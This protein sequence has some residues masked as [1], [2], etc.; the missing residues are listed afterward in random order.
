MHW[1]TPALGPPRP[2][3]AQLRTAGSS[4]PC[5]IRSVAILPCFS[6]ASAAEG[7]GGGVSTHATVRELVPSEGG[8]L[9]RHVFLPFSGRPRAAIPT[10]HGVHAHARTGAWM[11]TVRS[12]RVCECVVTHARAW[13]CARGGWC[14]DAYCEGPPIATGRGGVPPGR[15]RRPPAQMSPRCARCATWPGS[16]QC[17]DC[18]PPMSSWACSG[19]G[20]GGGTAAERQ[21]SVSVSEMGQRRPVLG[22]GRRARCVWTVM[23]GSSAAMKMRRDR[24]QWKWKR[25]V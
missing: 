1:P 21:L 12:A 14:S 22:A 5:A 16:A 7:F 8:W 17:P 11:R 3:R 9:Q 18:L 20:R 10:L 6:A 13:A 4:C 2:R 24:L 15:R 23:W 19:L 25:M